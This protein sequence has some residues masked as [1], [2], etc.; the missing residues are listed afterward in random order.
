[1]KKLNRKKKSIKIF[2]KLTNYKPETKKPNQ[3]KINKKT[4]PNPLKIKK[5]T[6]RNNI[7]FVY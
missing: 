2:K 7:V 1:L 4:K 6:P 3:T 5:K